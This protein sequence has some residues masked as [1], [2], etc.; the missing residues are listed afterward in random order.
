MIAIFLDTSNGFYNKFEIHFLKTLR[1]ILIILGSSVSFASAYCQGMCHSGFSFTATCNKVTFTPDSLNAGYVYAWNFGDGNTSSA[2]SP[3]HVYNVNSAGPQT[4]Q[5]QLIVTSP[6]CLADT[7]VKTVNLMI[8]ALPVPGL[9]SPSLFPP[10]VNCDATVDEP[11]YTLEVVNNSSGN[12]ASYQIDWGDDTAP[13]TGGTIPNPLSHDYTAVGL[14]HIV[15]TTTGQNGCIA[16]D[17]IPFFS[18]SN[19][20]VSIGNAGNTVACLPEL[21][22][23]PILLTEDN[24]PGTTYSIWV[25]DGSGDTTHYSHP[26]PATYP[27]YFTSAACDSVFQNLNGE[28]TIFI[29]AENPCD[30]QPGT[31]SQRVNR[32]AIAD[33]EI[34]PDSVNCVGTNFTFTNTSSPSIYFSGGSCRDS[35]VAFW[36]VQP[37]TG[38]LITQGSLSTEAGFSANFNQPGNYKIRLIYKS[39]FN[40]GCP[41]DTIIKSICVLPVPVANFNLGNAFGCYPH[42]VNATNTSNTISS[43]NPADYTWNVTFTG[44]E[45]GNSGGWN[46]VLPSHANTTNAN[47]QFDSAGVYNVTLVTENICGI[48]TSSSV[49]TI[50]DAPLSVIMALDTFCDMT[51]IMPMVE[52]TNSC[53]ATAVPTYSWQFP[54]GTP[55]SGVGPNPG[56]VTYTNNTNQV[57]QY[58]VSLTTTNACGP[59]T[60]NES[61]FIFPSPIAPGI[62]TN[63]PVCAG[64]SIQFNINSPGG[65]LA[66]QWQG[67]NG[68]VSNLANPSIPNATPANTGTYF[69]TVTDLV[70]GCSDEASVSVI[71]YEFPPVSAIPDQVGICIGESATFTASGAEIFTWSPQNY[72]NTTNGPTV[73]ASPPIP[74]TFNFV[75]TGTDANNCTQKDTV[76]LVVHPLPLVDAGDDLIVCEDTNQQLTGSPPN[77]TGGVGYWTGPH[78]TAGG[79]FNS[80][81]PGIYVVTYHYR[82][83]NNCEDSSSVEICVPAKPTAAFTV[84]ANSGCIGAAVSTTNSSNTLSNCVA[85]NYSW[86][87]VFN[88]SNCHEGLGIWSFASGTAASTNPSFLFNQAG[89]YEIILEVSNMCGTSSTTKLIT[90]GDTPEVAIDTISNFCNTAFFT[91]AFILND[92]ESPVNAFNWTFPGSLNI[93]SSTNANPGNVEYGLGAFTISLTVTNSCGSATDAEMFEVL[94]GPEVD[95]VLSDDFVCVGNTLNVVNNSSGDQLSYQWSAS[96]AGGLTFSSATAA[97]PVITAAGPVGSYTVTVVVGNP[98]CDPIT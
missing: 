98:V 91:P 26:P 80:P 22:N 42:T 3:V 38:Y 30:D 68:F 90:I 84:S 43:C 28:F 85:A 21:V 89:E 4:Y 79:L 86:N 33:F 54:G 70:S 93:P 74:D 29:I 12:I 24:V 23:F 73:I 92:C 96:P 51:T 62:T 82:Y 83:G 94:N 8:G 40:S 20:G 88:G 76:T 32:P 7:T 50:A 27:H 57:Q 18:G 77:G 36:S 16:W 35:M 71:V 59:T 34:S 63:S 9:E 46:F 64:S 25:N 97:S 49:V 17:T 2:Q 31:T 14:F 48:D 44:S 56:P 87:V 69:L 47:F 45:C 37:N 1:T 6:F 58:T 52:V 65:G 78:V 60:T 55:S 61:F 72:L 13:F 95:I 11:E 39:F 41:P 66:F 67:P 15:M 5:A 81:N 75:V 19:P 53:N 10:F